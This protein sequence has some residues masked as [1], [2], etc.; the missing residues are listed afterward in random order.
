MF[1]TNEELRLH[2]EA[3]HRLP[4]SVCGVV[5]RHNV[6][7]ENHMRDAHSRREQPTSQD[8][9]AAFLGELLVRELVRL[10]RPGQ[11]EQATAPQAP[12]LAQMLR[13][14]AGSQ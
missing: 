1:S 9:S 12:T 13:S 11:Q 8:T 6:E 3:A 5:L 7:M 4:C 14:L 10:L 2:M